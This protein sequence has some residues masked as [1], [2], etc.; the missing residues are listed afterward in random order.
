MKF[1]NLSRPMIR[2]FGNEMEVELMDAYNKTRRSSNGKQTKSFKWCNW[3]KGGSVEIIFPSEIDVKPTSQP[4]GGKK[5]WQSNRKQEKEKELSE[6][7][8]VRLKY[9]SFHQELFI[10]QTVENLFMGL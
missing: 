10:I 3:M 9:L 2:F 7:Q 6:K 8:I 4:S 5:R 1:P